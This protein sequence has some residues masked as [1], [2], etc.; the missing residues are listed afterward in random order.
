[1]SDRN[2]LQG[3]SGSSNHATNPVFL[4][5][6]DSEAQQNA[7]DYIDNFNPDLFNEPSVENN[8]PVINNGDT[9]EKAIETIDP[10]IP[11]DAAVYIEDFNPDLFDNQ[12]NVEQLNNGEHVNNERNGT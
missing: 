5:Y 12:V 10:V 8:T 4:T 9:F 6:A 7:Y 11:K 2:V 1:M 3:A